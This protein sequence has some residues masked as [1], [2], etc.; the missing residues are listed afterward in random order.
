MQERVPDHLEVEWQFEAADLDLVEN[1]LGE[2]PSASG[3]AVFP[4]A[5]KELIDTYYDTEDWRFYRAG[6]ALRVRRDGKS[7]EVTMKSLTPD[8]GTL[9]RR[10]EIS[11]PL[12]GNVKTPKGARGAVGEHVR[13]LVGPRDLRLLFEVRTRRR[14]FALRSEGSDGSGKVV[15]D[16]SE[17]IRRRERYAVVGEV[18]LDEA[19]I[20]GDE[21]A[22]TRLSRIEIELASDAGLRDGV[23]DF[24]D[25]LRDALR[26]RPTKHSKFELGLSAAGLNPVAPELGPKDRAERSNEKG[27]R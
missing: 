15:E 11:E 3:L 4:E 1:W 14:I 20:S 25:G 19:E 26:L 12:T 18:V 16:A 21:R 17:D 22:P 10:R 9:R 23:E 27:G 24:V 13:R 5:A 2:H 8:D 7:F 6:Y